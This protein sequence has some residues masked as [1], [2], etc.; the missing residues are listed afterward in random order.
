MKENRHAEVIFYEK[1][2]E[3]DMCDEKNSSVVI[4]TLGND[5]KMKIYLKKVKVLEEEKWKGPV[6]P[7]CYFYMKN[8]CP[9]PCSLEDYFREATGSEIIHYIVKKYCNN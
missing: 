3:C 8:D 2:K 4:N 6:C 7:R 9:L 1:N 5:I